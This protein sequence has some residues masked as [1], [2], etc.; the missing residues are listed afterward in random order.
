MT[1][2]PAVSAE[3]T[4]PQPVLIPLPPVAPADSPIHASAG[5]LWV[6]QAARCALAGSFTARPSVI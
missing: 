1:P 4:L 3:A 6:S 5:L 2:A